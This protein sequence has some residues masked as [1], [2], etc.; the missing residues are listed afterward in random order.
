MMVAAFDK[1]CMLQ[2]ME[3]SSAND[4]Q[5]SLLW[6]TAHGKCAFKFYRCKGKCNSAD[7]EQDSKHVQL[8][9]AAFARLGPVA[10]PV[11]LIIIA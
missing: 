1:L 4:T 11:S 5:C 10:R 8:F 9:K 3:A 2:H 6:D 7:S